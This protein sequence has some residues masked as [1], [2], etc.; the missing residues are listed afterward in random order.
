M[1]TGA[2]LG[3]GGA[4]S[5][6]VCPVMADHLGMTCEGVRGGG[7]VAAGL[8]VTLCTK[9]QLQFI[10]SRC[11]HLL[12]PDGLT[13]LLLVLPLLVTERWHMQ[14][15]TLISVNCSAGWWT[16]LSPDITCHSRCNYARHTLCGKLS[17]PSAYLLYC[18][19]LDMS[20]WNP[21]EY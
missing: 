13:F 7:W 21:E 10:E 16:G 8:N 20:I 4:A 1:Q 9:H 17:A 19:F 11:R 18:H 5:H 6:C 2:G 12:S 15:A 3:G 14:K